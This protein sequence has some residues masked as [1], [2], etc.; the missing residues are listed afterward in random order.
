[1][2]SGITLFVQLLFPGITGI[3]CLLG[4]T[5]DVFPADFTDV[6]LVLQNEDCYKRTAAWNS[7]NKDP[8]EPIFQ[9]EF[10]KTFSRTIPADIIELYYEVADGTSNILTSTNFLQIKT[11]EA[12]L[13]N[14]TDFDQYCVLDFKGGCRPV[15]SLPN[16]VDK[17]ATKT[18]SSEDIYHDNKNLQKFL[19]QYYQQSPEDLKDFVSKNAKIE[20]DSMSAAMIRSYFF[21][22][23]ASKSVKGEIGHKNHYTTKDYMRDTLSEKL[24]NYSRFGAAELPNLKFYYYNSFLHFNYLKTQVIYDQ[25][26]AIGSFLFITV[27]LWV[28]SQSIFITIFGILG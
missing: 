7:R 18:N 8:N 23:W 26:L 22:S 1:M 28:E 10:V 25:M 17:L 13:A 27:F 2:I 6:P 16:Q 3:L 12:A 14:V 19:R 5:A 20:S 24:W 9:P 4:H 15:R 11:F 21:I